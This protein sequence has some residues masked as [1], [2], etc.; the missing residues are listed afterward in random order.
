MRETVEKMGLFIPNPVFYISQIGHIIL[1]YIA[2]CALLHY[3]GTGWIPYITAVI[4]FT[5]AQ[6]SALMKS[7][8]TNMLMG[9]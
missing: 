4:L 6:V 9:I 5:T 7:S 3:Y 8:T 2:G 1:L